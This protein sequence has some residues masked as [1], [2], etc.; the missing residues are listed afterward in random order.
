MLEDDKA[1]DIRNCL[2]ISQIVAAAAKASL[3][4]KYQD[5]QKRVGKKK[6]FV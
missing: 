3:P 6:S 1:D 5:Y 2:A 4:F